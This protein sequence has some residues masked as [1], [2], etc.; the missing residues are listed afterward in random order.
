MPLELKIPS[1]RLALQEFVNYETYK[2][3]RLHELEMLDENYNNALEHLQDYVK[4]RQRTYNTMV[5]PRSFNQGDLVLY[6][7]Q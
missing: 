5:N 3:Q 7:N 1:L 4:R 2:K 6:E